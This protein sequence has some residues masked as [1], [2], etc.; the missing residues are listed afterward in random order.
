MEIMKNIYYKMLCVMPAKIV[1][2]LEHARGYKKVLNLKDPKYFGEKIQWIKLYGNLQRYSNYV[3]K[4][5]V[6]D[7][8]KQK[9]G[10]KYLNDIIGI[11][12][13]VEEINFEE[14]PN[15]FVIKGTHGCGYNLVCQNKRNLNIDE[16]KKKMKA[17]LETDFS[18][19][20][21]EP[22]YSKI[23]PR[24]LCE[25]YLYED[26]GVLTDYKIFCFNG[27]PAFIQVIKDRE[28]SQTQ[29]FFDTKWNR[30]ELRKGRYP[31]FTREIEKPIVLPE[32]IHISKSLSEGFPFVRVDFYIIKSRIIFGELTFTPAGGLSPFEPLEK[33]IEISKL[34]NLSLY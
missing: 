32:L 30:L 34:I 5:L 23:K 9:I 4:Y 26:G 14:L 18:K 21:K 2:Y 19:I 22:Q 1:L 28:F 29:D 17:W 15:E 25:K 16:A 31:S 27:Q 33:D 10:D 8:V 11:F 12:N 20:K 3:D 24:L 13:R 6:R 7:Y